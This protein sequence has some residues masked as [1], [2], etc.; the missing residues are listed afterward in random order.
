MN[1]IKGLLHSNLSTGS[2]RYTMEGL[3]K[4]INDSDLHIKLKR[5]HVIFNVVCP[6]KSAPHMR[7]LNKVCDRIESLLKTYEFPDILTYYL[8]PFNKPRT[9][10]GEGEQV[11]AAH[12]NGAYTYLVQKQV[13]IYRLEEFPKVAIHEACHHLPMHT[14]HWDPVSLMRLYDELSISKKGC[15]MMQQCMTDI[16]P[17]EAIVEAWANIYHIRFVSAEYDFRYEDLMASEIQHALM[18]T[19]KILEHQ[20]HHFPLWQEDTHSFSYIV[21]RT[22]LLFFAKEFCEM[23]Q[24]YD[25]IELTNFMI[26]KFNSPEFQK[27]LASVSIPSKDKSHMRMT[28]FGDF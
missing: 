9:F 22:V 5:P 11:G 16:R 17:N 27:A 2:T 7:L 23:G 3:T 18:Q 12:I 6:Q 26:K 4:F 28:R 1:G 24:P 14:D 8:V 25:T 13:F 21:L 19:K 10:P 20:K 15:D